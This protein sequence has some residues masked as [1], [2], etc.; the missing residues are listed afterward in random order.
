MLYQLLRVSWLKIYLV[1]PCSTLKRLVDIFGSAMGLIF[2]SPLFIMVA[3][4]VKFQDGGPILYRQIRVGHHGREFKVIKFRSMRVSTDDSDPSITADG[5]PRITPT[6]RFIRKTKIDE[7]PQLINVLKG[8]MSLVGPRPEVPHYVRLY[9]KEQ[10]AVLELQPGITDLASIE[11]RRE[12]ELL[13]SAADPERM[14]V[15]YCIPRK[16]E[17]NLQYV[18]RFGIL[19][20]LVIIAKTIMPFLHRSE[21]DFRKPDT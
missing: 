11:F 5:D 21:N 15:E 13:A 9:T 2:L 3:V 7:L 19:S 12:E 8:E 20:D 18:R 17:L 6:G 14:Y 4:G 16:I 1:K 10:L